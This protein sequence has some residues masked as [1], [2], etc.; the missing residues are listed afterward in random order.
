MHMSVGDN[1]PFTAEKAIRGALVSFRR[2]PAV[3]NSSPDRC[4]EAWDR[5]F[6]KPLKVAGGGAFHPSPGGVA[7]VL[8]RIF[9]EL[10]LIFSSTDYFPETRAFGAVTG[11]AYQAIAGR[12]EAFS[13]CYFWVSRLAVLQ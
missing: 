5:H 1:T 6:R 9:E 8:T 11:F 2:M 10:E 7:G 3:P 12:L 4:R 13:D